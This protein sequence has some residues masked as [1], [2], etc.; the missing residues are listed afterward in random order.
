M[1]TFEKI[2]PENHTK[3]LSWL[4]QKVGD[5]MVAEELTSKTFI[6]VYENLD[7]YDSEKSNLLTWI[8]TIANN[9]TIDYFRKRKLDT[10]SL[11]IQDNEGNEYL[12]ISSNSIDPYQ[13]LVNGELGDKIKRAI[14]QLP[15]TYQNIANLFFNCELTY[16]E[17]AEEMNISLGTVKGKLHRAKNLMKETLKLK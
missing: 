13:I 1:K 12:Q 3:V 2:Y 11:Q 10:I 16:D 17:I 14:K 8:M 5:K 15:N 9:T 6:K 7:T 4:S